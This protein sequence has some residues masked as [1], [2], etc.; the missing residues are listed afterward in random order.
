MVFQPMED[1][2]AAAIGDAN[3]GNT[4]VLFAGKVHLEV[5]AVAAE[6]FGK[7]LLNGILGVH[8]EGEATTSRNNRPVLALFGEGVPSNVAVVAAE[9]FARAISGE[10]SLTPKTIR[11]RARKARLQQKNDLANAA[12]LAVRLSAMKT[13]V[14][15]SNAAAEPRVTMPARRMLPRREEPPRIEHFHA[16]Q[17]EEG[18]IDCTCCALRAT[19]EMDDGDNED[20]LP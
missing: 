16:K 3:V 13:I 19:Y 20:Y 9:A 7:A 14:A 12:S 2:D 17:T 18:R 11:K 6:A 1:H 5:A 10:P 4:T 8:Q 15:N